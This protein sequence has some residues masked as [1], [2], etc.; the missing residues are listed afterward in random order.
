MAYPDFFL[1]VHTPCFCR[2]ALHINCPFCGMTRDFVL[3]AR[4]KQPV[5]NPFSGAAAVFM[6]AVYPG[7]VL[8]CFLTGKKMT[9]PYRHIRN[10]VLI[11]L[12]TM[13]IC[14]NIK[15]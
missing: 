7:F 4:G 8:F 5:W 15:L 11:I 10:T 14:N 1:S 13:M 12:L 6:F 3:I 9:V 2:S